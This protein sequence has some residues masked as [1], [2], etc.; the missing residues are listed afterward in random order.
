M[1]HYVRRNGQAVIAFPETVNPFAILHRCFQLDGLV[2]MDQPYV[3]PPPPPV[4]AGVR[5]TS[6]AA[7]RALEWSGKLAAQEKV[8]VDH[9]LAHQDRTFTRME[10]A[11]D[12]G[13]G[14][15]S[16]CGRVNKLIAEPFAVL[17][18]LGR[19]TC[20]STGNS[21]NELALRRGA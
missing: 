15:Q 3:E 17:E 19:R 12:L 4:K 2:P 7:Y 1:S 8:V 13:L 14:I 18:E 10:L 11:D 6:L 20:Q 9:F 16:I 5:D 21:A